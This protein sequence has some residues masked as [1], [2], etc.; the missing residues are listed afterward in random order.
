M[1]PGTYTLRV[2]YGDQQD[3]KP[4]EVLP[5]P[6][7]NIPAADRRAKEE[8]ILRV[9][10]ELDVAAK[11]VEH[12]RGARE[13]VERISKRIQGQEDPAAQDIRGREKTI[14]DSIEELIG[15][16]TAPEVQGNRPD[17][18]LFS[19]RLGSVYRSIQSSWEAPTEAQRIYLRRSET[20]LREALTE[21][22]R[23][24]EEDMRAYQDAVEATGLPRF[25]EF[26]PFSLP[27]T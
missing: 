27:L 20:K 18:V 12:L 26:S 22:N 5:D 24:F 3:T 11:A 10:R 9:G 8:M 2:R 17:P 21:I 25:E 15:R 6:R 7:Q 19:V 16:I 14:K 13:A 1:L 23:F 4:V